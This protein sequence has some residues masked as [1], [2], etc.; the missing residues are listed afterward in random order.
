MNLLNTEDILVIISLYGICYGIIIII[1]EKNSFGAGVAFRVSL[2]WLHDYFSHLFNAPRLGSSLNR[3]PFY[4]YYFW[5][6]GY[7]LVLKRQR[8]GFLL[9]STKEPSFPYIICFKESFLVICHSIL[10]SWMPPRS[11]PG[12]HKSFIN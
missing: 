6:G 3:Q 2:T 7:V 12:E 9:W 11:I 8:Q 10:K 5:I 1:T 4:A